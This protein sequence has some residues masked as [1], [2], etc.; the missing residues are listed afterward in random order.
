MKTIYQIIIVCILCL[1]C[2]NDAKETERLLQGLQRSFEKG[3]EVLTEQSNFTRNKLKDVLYE[4]AK[5]KYRAILPVADSLE[6][7]FSSI[8]SLLSGQVVSES[9][10][11]SL[12]ELVISNQRNNFQELLKN[13][14][15]QFGLRE[16]EVQQLINENEEKL[17][18]LD[19]PTTFTVIERDLVIERIRFDLKTIE[20]QL[21]SD[22]AHL[23][24]GHPIRCYFGILPIIIPNQNTVKRGERF[25]AMIG[26]APYDY[27]FLKD[28]IKL[29]IDGKIVPFDKGRFATYISEPI[30][31]PHKVI[32]IS[33]KVRDERT[34]KFVP[35]WDNYEYQIK[36]EPNN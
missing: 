26:I 30:E 35:A 23:S 13:K 5:F 1:S 14:G 24:G 2:S 16:I 21:L 18:H 28:D 3:S 34:N 25:S 10:I 7:D 6:K 20:N 15:I 17:T 27:E 29:T 12:I 36:T 32:S 8:Y 11:D 31:G 22:L 9:I 4:D 19:I 33:C